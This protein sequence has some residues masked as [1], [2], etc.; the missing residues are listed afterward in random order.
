VRD[1]VLLNA[2]AALVAY[3]GGVANPSDLAAALREGMD[4][5]REAVDSGA[6]GRVLEQWVAASQAQ[7]EV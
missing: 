6:S 3:E 7:R 2:A 1:A 5:A 4:R